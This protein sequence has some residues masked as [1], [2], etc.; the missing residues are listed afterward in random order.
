[1]CEGIIAH[2]DK[3]FKEAE[4]H[5]KKASKIYDNRLEPPFS[6]ALNCLQIMVNSDK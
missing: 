6:L 5:F 4:I 1:M 3:E 2:C